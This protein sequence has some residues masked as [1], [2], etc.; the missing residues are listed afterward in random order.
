MICP[1]NNKDINILLLEDIS[2][3]A[4]RLFEEASFHV[5]SISHALSEEELMEKIANVDI[6][7]IRSKTKLTQRVIH[8]A[9]NLKAVGCFCIG[10]DQTDLETCERRGIPVFNSPFASTRSVAEVAMAEIVML[11]R[12][13][14]EHIQNMNRGNWYKKITKDCCEVRGKTLGVI[15]YGHVGSQLG[16]LAE[17]FGMTVLY[18][19]IERKLPLGNAKPVPSL[20]FV[21]KNSQFVSLHVPKTEQTHNMIAK[22]QLAM[23]CP[24]SYLLNLSRGSVVNVDDLAFSLQTKHLAGAAVDVFPVEP[25][26]DGEGVFSSPLQTCFNTI[27]TPHIGGSTIE[28]QEAIGSEVAQTLIRFI[29]DGTTV[30]SVNFPQIR[31]MHYDGCHCLL[32]VHVNRQGVLKQINTLLQDHNVVSQLLGTTRHIGYMVIELEREVE[33]EILQQIMELETTIKVYVLS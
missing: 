8:R 13:V 19:D 11:S 14:S 17:S 15:G 12:K 5:E 20:E 27:L 2:Q 25:N 29:K 3:T 31:P 23:M 33:T 26:H 9:R 22:E 18:Y 30:G 6:V 32:H 28:A 1:P 4:I 16:L 24:G 10:T 7:G 21:L